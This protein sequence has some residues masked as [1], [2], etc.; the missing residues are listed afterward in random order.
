VNTIL[1][2]ATFSLLLAAPLAAGETTSFDAKSLAGWRTPT[3]TWQVAGRVS[4]D[5]QHPERL[6]IAPGTG[7]FVNGPSDVAGNPNLVTAAEFA[8]AEVH[9]E[10]LVPRGS[11]SGVYLMGRYE[12]QVLDRAAEGY[13]SYP[14][15]QCGGVYPRW[16]G[17][18]NVGGTP[19]RVDATRLAGEWQSFEI[20]FRAPRFDANGK[21]TANARFLRV[22]HNGQLVQENVEVDGPTRASMADDERPTGPLMLQGDHGPVA[23]RNLR[24][25]PLR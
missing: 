19:P 2:I 11:N 21:K 16:I 6:Q 5:A 24:V 20:V 1:R 13:G 12:V 9:V 17:E 15:N 10:F 7:V 4:L 22:V 8:D 14:G 23:Y 25:E 3:G 18:K